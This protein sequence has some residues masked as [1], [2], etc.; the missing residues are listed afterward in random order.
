MPGTDSDTSSLSPAQAVEVLLYLFK[1]ALSMR[2]EPNQLISRLKSSVWANPSIIE[3]RWAR[4][5]WCSS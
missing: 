3:F 5:L 1:E 4:I 2:A